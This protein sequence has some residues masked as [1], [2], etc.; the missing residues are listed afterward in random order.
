MGKFHFNTKRYL[1]LTY[2]AVDLLLI[3]FDNGINSN[4]SNTIDNMLSF[5]MQNHNDIY[6]KDGIEMKIP[7]E[8]KRIYQIFVHPIY[9]KDYKA[10]AI[11]N[12]TA[13]EIGKIVTSHTFVTH[14]TNVKPLISVCTYLTDDSSE[15]TKTLFQVINSMSYM[16]YTKVSG[17][18]AAK[19]GIKT[20]TPLILQTRGSK[21]EKYQEIKVQ[22]ISFQVPPGP[23]PRTILVRTRGELT[24]LLKPGDEA[25]ITGIFMP[26]P[27][28]TYQGINMGLITRTF[29]EALYIK[30]DKNAYVD[31]L[32][33]LSIEKKKELKSFFQTTEE[34]GVKIYDRLAKSIAPEIFGHYDVKKALLIL[35]VGGVTQIHTDGLKIRGDLHICLMGDPGVSKSQLLKFIC[36]VAP[37]AV[38]TNGRGSTGVGLTAAVIQDKTSNEVVLEGGALVLAD[39][40]ICCIDEFDKMD[41]IERTSIHEV[42]EQQTVSIAKA[43]ITTTLNARTSVLAAANPVYGRYDTRRTPAE[44]IDLPIS[45]LSRFDL[46]WLILDKPDSNFDTKLAAHVLYVHNNKKPPE[47]VFLHDDKIINPS[48]NHDSSNKKNNRT[49]KDDK[50][51]LV[52]EPLFLNLTP[53]MIRIYIAFAKEY[54]PAIPE[55]LTEWLVS[56]YV[57][58]RLEDNHDDFQ[59][60]CNTAR[61]LLSIIRI[62]QAIAKLGLRDFVTHCDIEESLRLIRMSKDS[63]NKNKI[64]IK[65]KQQDETKQ[66]FYKI[67]RDM[68]LNQRK[69]QKG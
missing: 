53:E 24:R 26:E 68:I 28:N 31:E 57:K 41:E 48:S 46:L 49:I 58:I 64:C 1:E 7:P 16:P 34:N 42:M 55:D 14:V 22:E 23:V 44:N 30:K 59:K 18:L 4:E 61:T 9:K 20:G 6:Q 13:I 47:D 45:L 54:Q 29:L 32:R 33:K 36:N 62:S 8:L 69:L 2:T 3:E 51:K 40:G 15:G 38:Y 60:S 25:I 37:R 35:M 67:I 12:I 56:L 65:L 50:N 17:Q 27:L 66:I 63:L 21:F 10:K 11:R 39:M 43:G 52:S 19:I 5:L